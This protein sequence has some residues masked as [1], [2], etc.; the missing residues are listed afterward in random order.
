MAFLVAALLLAGCASAPSSTSGKAVV[1][2]KGSDTMLLLVSRWAEEFMKL[3]PEIA[4]YAE[5]GG[6]ETGIDAL[7]N[8]KAE[9]S[10]ASRTLRAEEARLLLEKR[11]SLGYSVLTA[12]DAL[13]V[14]LHPDNPVRNLSLEQTRDIFT[15]RRTLWTEFGGNPVPVLVVGRQPNSGTQ[16]FFEEHVLEGAAY[17][18]STLTVPT[19]KAVVRMVKRHRGAIGYGGLAFGADVTHASI[20]GVAPTAGNVRDGSYPISRYLYLYAAEP[21]A[22]AVKEF[23]DWILSNHGQRVVSDVGYIPLW[24]VTGE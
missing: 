15:G 23:I 12:K 8:G 24:D 13:S 19:T 6:T 9:L 2:I 5:G 3:H 20:D 1:R 4:I 7:I 17:A 11:R 10:A 22:G 21:P 16:L 14:Y 18:S